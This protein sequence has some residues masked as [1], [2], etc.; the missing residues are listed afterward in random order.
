LHFSVL[1]ILLIGVNGCIPEF[2]RPKSDDVQVKSLETVKEEGSATPAHISRAQLRE[3]IER[4]AF[5][6]AGRLNPL[7]EAVENEATTP[8]QR[9]KVHFWKG[10]LVFSLV[11]ISTGSA[12]ETALLDM[13]VL[14]TLIRIESEERLVPEIFSG[15][16]GQKWLAAVRKSEE[17][18]W[19]L[20][21]KLL[22]PK[23]QTVMHQL[24]R[25]WRIKN[26]EVANITSVRF[27]NFAAEVGDG[28]AGEM[29]QPGGLLPEVSE[30]TRAVDEIRRTTERAI[31]LALISPHLVRLEAENLLYDFATQ[32]EFKEFRTGLRNFSEA[33]EK[34]TA[35]SDQIPDWLS[36]ERQAAVDQAMDRLF[37]EREELFA[38]IDEKSVQIKELLNQIQE[39]LVVGESL[40]GNVTTTLATIDSLVTRLDIDKPASEKKGFRIEDY[41]DTLV[42]AAVTAKEIN[43][44]LH[45]LDHLL[46]AG[47][48]EQAGTPIDVGLQK[49]DRHVEHWIFLEFVALAVLALFI[50]VVVVGA[51]LTYR[52]SLARI[53]SKR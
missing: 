48:D 5:R 1:A 21:A 39:T 38:K 32:P 30:A 4:F 24:I 44:V 16:R 29:I 41:R 31:F 50:A 8:E 12:P 34:L 6:Y 43:Q 36:S 18:I 47:L 7:L 33:S 14:V 53:D 26:P 52:W 9:L 10:K 40:T 23:Q 51:L 42:E 20:A 15:D 22:D 25:D 13:V 45:S 3:E 19:S 49:L 27:S 35:V 11:E 17:E 46:A 28:K 37:D 2:R